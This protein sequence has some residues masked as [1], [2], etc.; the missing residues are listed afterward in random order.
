[1]AFNPEDAALP[2]KPRA[3]LKRCRERHCR[4]GL[5]LHH[6]QSRVRHECPYWLVALATSPASAGE[7]NIV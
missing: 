2:T 5:W 4:E 6:P 3:A 1:M 7:A